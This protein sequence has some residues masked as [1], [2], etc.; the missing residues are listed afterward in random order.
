[1]K[2]IAFEAKALGPSPAKA[3]GPSDR[4]FGWTFTGIFLF[5]GVLGVWRG[6][7]HYHPW[8]FAAAALTAAVTLTRAHWLSPFNRAWMKLGEL[9]HHVVSPAVMAIMFFGVF[10]PM[11]FVMRRFGWDA[12]RR[13]FDPAAKSYWIERQPPGPAEDSFKDLF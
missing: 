5:L 1:M 13:A 10:T 11:G 9:L 8:V 3:L 12:M 7:T 4:S 6:G 2:T